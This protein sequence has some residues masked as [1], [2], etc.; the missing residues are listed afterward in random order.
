[1]KKILISLMFGLFLV[2]YSSAQS[3]SDSL[4]LT[5]DLSG[6]STEKGEVMVGL[7]NEEGQWLKT[8]LQGKGSEVQGG[9]AQVVFKNLPKGEYAIST[10]HDINANGELDSNFMGIPNEP[11]AFSNDAKGLFGPASFKDAKF[12]VSQDVSISIKF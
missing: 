4:V 3:K 11:Y 8:N 7:Y 10:F 2:Q 6:L 9:S 12:V 5:V 1:M